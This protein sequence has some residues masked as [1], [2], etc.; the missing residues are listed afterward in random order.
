MSSVLPALVFFV[1]AAV[2]AV[3]PGR[4]RAAASLLVPIA[5]AVNLLMFV[6]L[7]AYWQ[8]ALFDYELTLL[9][10]DKLSLL[11]GYLF[12][13]A[14]FI[15]VVYSLHVRDATQQVSAGAPRPRTRRPRRSRRQRRKRSA[16]P[17]PTDSDSKCSLPPP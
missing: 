12:H 10:V 8:V 16:G 5:G 4:L 17:Y 6:D 9:R 1:G 15:G 13:L 2:V 3:L 7:G 14:A 11:F